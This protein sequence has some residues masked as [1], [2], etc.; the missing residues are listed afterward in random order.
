MQENRIQ[1]VDGTEENV[2]SC[3]PS[4]KRKLTWKIKINS[5]DNTIDL[6]IY[7]F[8]PRKYLYVNGTLRESIF[9]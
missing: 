1:I 5:K 9:K 8:Y 4:L 3:I 2:G 6:I 7:K